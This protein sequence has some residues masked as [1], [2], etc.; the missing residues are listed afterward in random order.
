M[1]G[2]KQHY[3]GLFH[4]SSYWGVWS[5]ILKVDG[6]EVT[7]LDLTPINPQWQSSW[8]ELAAQ[9]P[10]FRSHRTC[11]DRKDKQVAVLP[12]P[13]VCQMIMQFGEDQTRDLLTYSLKEINNV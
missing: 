13:V 8:D 6:S 3:P 4:Y 9:H 7:E 5:K 11:L 12:W 2:G 10:K 1:L